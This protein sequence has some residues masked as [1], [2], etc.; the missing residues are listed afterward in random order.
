[1][2]TII[3]AGIEISLEIVVVLRADI[4]AGLINELAFTISVRSDA[5]TR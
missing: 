3:S 4:G 5:S 2:P 1:M